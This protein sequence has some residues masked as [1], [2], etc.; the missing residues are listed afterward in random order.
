MSRTVSNHPANGN[1][2]EALKLG[3]VFRESS[4]R[5]QKE[6]AQQYCIRLKPSELALLKEWAEHLGI[7]VSEL[8][9]R[10]TLGDYEA[11]RRKNRR[12]RRDDK[13]LGKL[14]GALGQSRLSSN[15]NQIAKAAN[16]GALPVGDDLI[17]ELTQACFDI[18]TMRREL[19]T[20]LGLKAED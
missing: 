4:K 9:R 18:Q 2:I 8:I 14:L 12:P 20:A 7:S 11:P 1:E 6:I 17:A 19:I 10:R 13:L 15:M 5:A 3:S 16:M